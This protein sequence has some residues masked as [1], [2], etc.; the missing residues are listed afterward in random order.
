M[1]RTAY[2]QKMSN[3][4]LE[5]WTLT[6]TGTSHVDVGQVDAGQVD[7]G[8]VDAGQVDAQPGRRRS[9]RRHYLINNHY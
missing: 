9:G 2:M 3:V 7:A 8:Q 5:K 1:P 4:I 6:L